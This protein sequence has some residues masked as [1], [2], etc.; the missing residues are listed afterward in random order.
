MYVADHLTLD[1]LR[2]RA[3]AEKDKRLFLR[4]RAVYL[5]ATGLTAPEVAAALGPSRRAVQRWIARYNA[6][7]P[8]ALGDRPRPGQPTLLP[9]SEV[10]RLRERLDAGPTPADGVCTLRA[11]DVH[12]ILQAEF[13]VA[14]SLPGVYVLLHRLG[15]SCLDP[16]P[17]HPKS[18]AAA[19]EDFKKKSPT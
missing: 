10:G 19:Q 14:Y 8:D 4:L 1:E 16:R 11:K 15:Y 6:D 12:A 7:G 13:G 18:D 5:A 17:R 3:D 9:E 2:D